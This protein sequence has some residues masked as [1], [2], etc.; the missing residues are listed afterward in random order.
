MK[1]ENHLLNF[2]QSRLNI[3]KHVGVSNLLTYKWQLTKISTSY[4]LTVIL[5][6]DEKWR[7]LQLNE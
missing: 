7:L 2:R 6:K 1:W 3:V 4:R 5:E